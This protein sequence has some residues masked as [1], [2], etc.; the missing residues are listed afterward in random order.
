MSS[1]TGIRRA[2]AS[3]ALIVIGASM[4]SVR[5]VD[6]K[7][8]GATRH[9]QAVSSPRGT[10]TPADGLCLTVA[11]ALANGD[12]AQCGSAESLVVNERDQI[13]VCY[14]L[15]NM[16]GQTLNYHSLRDT[17]DGALFNQ[18]PIVVTDGATYQYNRIVTAEV[19]RDVTSTWTAGAT[20]PYEYSTG[21]Y[22]FIDISATGTEIAGGDDDMTGV[23]LPFN[24]DVYGETNRICVGNNG[25][26]AF[27]TDSC[28]LPGFNVALPIMVP[29][30][31]GGPVMFPL[32]TDLYSGGKLLAQLMGTAPAR[33]VVVEWYQ[34]NHYNDGADDPGGVTFEVVFDEASGNFS[35]QYQ[36]TTFGSD[37]AWDHGGTATVGVEN[38]EGTSWNQYSYNE[39]VLVDASAIDWTNHSA[40]ALSA[41]ATVHLDV[42]APVANI[43]PTELDADAAAGTS[44][45]ALLTIGN[46]GNRD[47]V[48]N[49]DEASARAHF[50]PPG[51]RYA[52]PFHA[53]A[54][55]SKGPPPHPRGIVGGKTAPHPLRPF[56]AAA[57]P[58]Y[59]IV[60]SL[61]GSW[62]E[63]FDA[64]DP[65]SFDRIAFY[66]G[67]TYAGAFVGDDFTHEYVLSYNT[68][69]LD[70][71]DTLTGAVAHIAALP[72][73]PNT[74]WSS[75][76][77]DRTTD[78]LFGLA[79][80]CG[81]SSS[82]YAI[83]PAT[84]AY[85][86]V[87]TTT[88]AQCLV[89]IAVDDDGLMY[90]LDLIDDALYAIDKT[91]GDAALVGSLGFN[92]NYAQDIA[93]DRS[94]GVLYLGGM[95]NDA[96]GGIYTIDTVTGMATLIEP[97]G[98]LVEVT[99]LDIA[100]A[101][102]PCAHPSDIPW[103]TQNP[104]SGSTPGSSSSPVEV[105]FDAAGLAAGTYSAHLCVR[106][107]DTHQR[108]TDVPVQFSVSDP[109]DT[110]FADGFDGVP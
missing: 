81:T 70:T 20:L 30:Y 29:N 16:S 36:T 110:I 27:G 6:A 38:A 88:D 74:S 54:E 101:G 76:S 89:A 85:Q 9:R 103:L 87:G 24:V 53:P 100:L 98:Y 59:T 1:M 8:P 66:D 77:W 92:A 44:T 67:Q 106:S 97:L 31:F 79:G 61:E 21:T 50:P 69:Q 68:S 90:G 32:W 96:N 5:P 104:P 80:A 63:T 72:L 17:V 33:K 60:Y 26:I 108:T 10:C 43:S 93:F 107:N 47:L 99:A 37:P 19:T 64:A 42:G 62:Y 91:N 95:D 94:N 75:L 40:E 23:I 41:S 49:F 71:L 109:T 22:D 84:G 46:T 25:A 86:L 56:G 2:F 51:S 52:M 18:M 12:P 78:T 55:T 83:D 34:K 7:M 39:P 4:A 28:Y 105:T 11:L 13:N 58:A 45:T 3:V 15:T 82:I 73:P 57:V 14:T 65:T 102:G 48:W 35:F